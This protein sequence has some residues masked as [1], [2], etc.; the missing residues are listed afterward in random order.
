MRPNIRGT[1]DKKKHKA[2]YSQQVEALTAA[3][4]WSGEQEDREN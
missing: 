1:S 4:V 3:S 2:Q